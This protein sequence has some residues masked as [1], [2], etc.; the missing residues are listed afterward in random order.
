MNWHLSSHWIMSFS[1]II[2][3]VDVSVSVSVSVLHLCLRSFLYM[4]SIMLSYRSSSLRCSLW[5]ESLFCLIINV[6]VTLLYALFCIFHNLSVELRSLWWDWFTSFMV[7]GFAFFFVALS[8]KCV[9]VQ[10]LYRLSSFQGWWMGCQQ[11][12]MG[13]DIESS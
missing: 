4:L 11:M 7:Y 13:R 8:A 1:R 2:I 6:F 5:N 10:H 12:D 9:I 3:G